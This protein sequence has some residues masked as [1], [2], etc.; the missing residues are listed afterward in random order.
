MGPMLKW[1]TNNRIQSEPRKSET[2][3]KKKRV[4]LDNKRKEIKKKK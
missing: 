1:A 4:P 3:I 2:N